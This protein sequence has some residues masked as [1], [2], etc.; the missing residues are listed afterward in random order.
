MVGKILGW[1]AAP[2]NG[3]T[4]LNVQITDKLTR[5][6]LEVQNCIRFAVILIR[7]VLDKT[8]GTRN[9]WLLHLYEGNVFYISF[10]RIIQNYCSKVTTLYIYLT[11]S[12]VYFVFSLKTVL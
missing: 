5:K 11:K 2:N 6:T 3:Q 1:R 7:L 4:E 8:T 9:F 12:L 10:F